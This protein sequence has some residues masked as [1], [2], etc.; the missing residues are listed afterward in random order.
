MHDGARTASGHV[1]G[2]G[3]EAMTEGSALGSAFWTTQ[4]TLKRM[5][6]VSPGSVGAVRRPTADEGP[7][8]GPAGASRS[9]PAP[10][11]DRRP[12]PGLR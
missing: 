6:A 3:P 12:R 2:V 7:G 1:G 11:V 8:S 5:T 10:P 4:D 9:V